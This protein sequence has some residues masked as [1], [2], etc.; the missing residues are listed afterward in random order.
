[1]QRSKDENLATKEQEESIAS[2]ENIVLCEQM[3]GVCLQQRAQ[4]SDKV[5]SE[6]E[7]GAIS[8]WSEGQGQQGYWNS[9]KYQNRGMA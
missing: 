3:G 1:M 8:Q 6:R 4:S 5:S 9:L 7:A 2:K